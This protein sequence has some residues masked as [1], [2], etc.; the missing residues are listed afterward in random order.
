MIT[1]SMADISQASSVAQSSA[2]QSGH[3]ENFADI[4]SQVQ[5]QL[6]ASLPGNLPPSAYVA[7]SGS[8]SVEQCGSHIV[9]GV[10]LVP[11]APGYDFSSA[12]PYLNQIV[13]TQNTLSQMQA[14]ASEENS[15][16]V[17]GTSLSSS[18][19]L[20]SQGEG[21]ASKEQQNS[22]SGMSI[23]QAQQLISS[24]LPSNYPPSAYVSRS[25]YYSLETCGSHVVDGV[26]LIPGA[27]GYN[28]KAARPYIAQIADTQRN[29]FSSQPAGEMN[30]SV[31]TDSESQA[32][33]S[34][35][36]AVGLQNTT[37]D[38]LEYKSTINKLV[39]KLAAIS[40]AMENNGPS[41]LPQKAKL[42]LIQS[43]L[44]QLDKPNT[45]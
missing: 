11:G 33:D 26:Q 40:V 24:T 14:A 3:T 8:Y 13:Q 15:V 12:L 20:N 31:E 7:R 36:S 38:L 25:S 22:P 35:A 45:N 4:F 17:L 1:A 21:I 27:P 19:N 42:D 5:N 30:P 23:G 10:Q 32:S 9:N 2:S 16:P 44:S 6:A 39:Q 37:V 28:S 29:L 41:I 34:D 18:Q 43:V